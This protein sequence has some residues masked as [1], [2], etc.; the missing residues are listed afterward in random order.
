MVIVGYDV[1]TSVFEGYSARHMAHVY[2]QTKARRYP[3][4][5]L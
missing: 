4:V 5:L 1:C 2:D 3:A